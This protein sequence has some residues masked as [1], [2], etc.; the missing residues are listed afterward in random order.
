MFSFVYQFT[1]DRPV[2]VASGLPLIMPIAILI[3]IAAQ[4]LYARRQAAAGVLR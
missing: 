4:W 3:L 2:E 1:S